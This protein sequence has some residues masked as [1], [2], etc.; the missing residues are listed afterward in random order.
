MANEKEHERES[1]GLSEVAGFQQFE[2][3]LTEALIL[4]LIDCLDGLDKAPLDLVQVEKIPNGQGVYQLY[5]DD[6]L[7]YI[8]KTDTD[9][10]LTTRLATHASKISGRPNLRG[11][12]SFKAVQVLVFSAMELETLLIRHYKNA[13]SPMSWQHSGFG[14]NDPGRQRDH[15]KYKEAHFDLRHPIDVTEDL[16]QP[17]VIAAGSTVREA[18][19]M[20]K[21]ALP[22]NF[23][24]ERSAE[25]DAVLENDIRLSSAADGLRQLLPLL[26]ADWQATRLPGYVILYPEDRGYDH[27]EVI[28]K[29]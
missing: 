19:D 3:A 23:R 6:R 22:Y 15:T 4:Q 8:G 29:S 7:E 18:L 28:A 11:R 9:A 13:G 24:Y 14:S 1:E 2:F 25:L 26:P 17:L 5:L 12:V 21:A 20:L 16:A 27:G 10:G